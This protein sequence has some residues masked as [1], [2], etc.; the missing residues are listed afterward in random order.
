MRLLPY[1][2]IFQDLPST[3]LLKMTLSLCWYRVCS[4]VNNITVASKLT[5]NLRMYTRCYLM[6]QQKGGGTLHYTALWAKRLKVTLEILNCPF[7][8]HYL[9][10]NNSTRYTTGYFLDVLLPTSTLENAKLKVQRKLFPWM[11]KS[12]VSYVNPK[13]WT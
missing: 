4:G 7:T 6:W 13:L 2:K 5:L 1:S 9:L 12:K 10:R 8:K 3:A 11:A